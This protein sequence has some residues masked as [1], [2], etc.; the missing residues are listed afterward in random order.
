L[1]FFGAGEL[2]SNSRAPPPFSVPAGL[3]AATNSGSTTLNAVRYFGT[4]TGRLGQLTAG[5]V[6]KLLGYPFPVEV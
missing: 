6:G 4:Y 3:T 5:G 1:F 2:F